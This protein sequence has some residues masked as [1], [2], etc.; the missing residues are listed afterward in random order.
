MTDEELIEM[1]K[2]D[3][4]FKNKF[5]FLISEIIEKEMSEKSPDYNKIDHLSELYCKITGADKIIEQRSEAHVQKIL[6]EARKIKPK[7][8]RYGIKTL[9]AAAASVVLLLSANAVSTSAFGVNIFKQVI[10]YDGK[11][12]SISYSNIENSESETLTDSD[13]YHIKEECN[14]YGIVPETPMYLPEGF[15]IYNVENFSFYDETSVSINYEKDD[16]KII[17]GYYLFDNIEDMSRQKFPCDYFNITNIQINGCPAIVSKEDDQYT[18]VYAKDNLLMSI[19]MINVP[20]EECD[21][22]INSI[23]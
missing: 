10:H 14:K 20:Y 22:I 12:V 15:E 18:L 6:D 5:A 1:L 9:T 23:K 19:Y 3:P 11:G 13:P 16:M 17:I 7:R 8:K 2:N 4:D 21:K